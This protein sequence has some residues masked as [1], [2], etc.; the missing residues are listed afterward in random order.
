M[1]AIKSLV[2]SIMVRDGSD[3]SRVIEKEAAAHEKNIV[4]TG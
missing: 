3:R 4:S 1:R 2:T